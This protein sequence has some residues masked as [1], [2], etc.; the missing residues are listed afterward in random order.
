[1]G[2][3]GHSTQPLRSVRSRRSAPNA[4]RVWARRQSSHVKCL[5]APWHTAPSS[6]EKSSIHSTHDFSVEGGP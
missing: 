2:E 3:N 6:T 1:M 4:A 5:A